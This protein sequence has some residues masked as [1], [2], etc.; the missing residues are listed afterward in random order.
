[1][2]GFA[3]NTKTTIIPTLR[4]KDAQGGL[5]TGFARPLVSRRISWLPANTALLLTPNS[6]SGTAW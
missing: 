4:Y 6:C 2:T 1:M 5:L 3:K